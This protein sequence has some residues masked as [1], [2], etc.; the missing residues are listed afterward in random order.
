MSSDSIDRY[1]QLYVWGY[2]LVRSL[3]L[4]ETMTRSE[5]GRE[6]D[7]GRSAAAPLGEFG[8][9][10]LLSDPGYRV[11][12]APNVDTLYS[13]AWVD[14]LEG[15]LRLDLPDFGERYYAFQFGYADTTC[16]TV[17]KRTHGGVLGPVTIRWAPSLA[18]PALTSGQLGMELD[19]TCR[20]LMIAGRIMVDSSNPRDLHEVHAL[21]EEI[22]LSSPGT[23]A[24]VP[25][26]EPDASQSPVASE[27]GPGRHFFEQLSRVM[28]DLSVEAVDPDVRDL[29]AEVGWRPGERLGAEMP[30][31]AL[32][33]AV[34]RGFAMVRRGV[35]DAGQVR[36]GWMINY[37][38]VE[39]GRDWLLRASVAM[40][41]IYINPAEEALYPVLEVDSAGRGLVGDHRYRLR[42]TPGQLPPVTYFWSL[43]M[44]HAEGLLVANPLSRYSVGDRS[45]HLRYEPDGS[46]ELVVS[47]ER[48]VEGE[49]NWLP[50]PEGGFRLMLRL[51][52]PS[53]GCLS[54]KWSPPA[55]VRDGV[56]DGGAEKPD[57]NQTKAGLAT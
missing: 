37:A 13:V 20:F 16:H 51:Y 47:H 34:A 54:G 28:D 12:V 23:H 33:D 10:K 48:P 8:H 42:F 26:A 50:A 38:G 9:Q 3:Q 46:L 7:S 35:A 41:Q 19:C 17:G 11:G 27:S 43:T 29:L 1:E 36:N 40:A 25:D 45:P 31:F 5:P 39:F 24:R 44:Y 4:R 18:E 56:H 49:D 14:L 55:L 21:Q 2:P 15:D 30:R 32:D 57:P 6:R 52:G 22:R 53:P